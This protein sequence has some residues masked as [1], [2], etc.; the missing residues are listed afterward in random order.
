MRG[1]SERLTKKQLKHDQFLES[2]YGVW[3][4]AQDHLGV[5]IAALVGVVVAV[6]LG[7]RVGGSAVGG[8][9]EGGN[10]E[11]ERALS[12][13]RTQFMAG[14]SEA[15]LAALEELRKQHRG[16]RAAREGTYLLGN[17]LLEAGEGARAAQVF[18]EFLREPLHDDLL[19]DAARLAIASCQEET[20]DMA[21]ALEAYTALWKGEGRTGTR[22][23]A[24]RGAAR[25][26][27]ALGQSDRAAAIYEEIADAYPDA[28]EAEEARF[29]L[30][31][32]RGGRS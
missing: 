8:G 31:E 3:A 16:T 22:L 14:Q 9:S 7:V 30:L 18:E 11:A 5:V 26:A 12:L 28:P 1:V 25:A 24:A 27:E 29:R 4:Y 2:L 32:L 17:A 20:G 6:V 15:G 13:A 10:P 19:Q 23:L 21:A